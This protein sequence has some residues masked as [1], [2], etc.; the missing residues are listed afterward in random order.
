[1][2]DALGVVVPAHDE[3]RLLPSC[4]AALSGAASAPRAQAVRV[5]VVV[6]LDR[7]TD[8]SALV[9]ALHPDVHPLAL[10]AGNVGRARAVGVELV[11]AIEQRTPPDRVWLATTDADSQVPTDWLTTQLALAR[12]GAAAVVGTVAVPD[13]S[14]HEA[15]VRER[16]TASYQ[17]RERHPHV[18]G[19]NLGVRLSA[20]R[21]AGGFPPLAGDEDVALVAALGQHGVV[22]TSAIPVRTSARTTPRV[23]RGFGAHLLALGDSGPVLGPGGAAAYDPA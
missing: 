12:S 21:S 2:I 19:A 1:V 14:G 3:E 23:R 10:D 9:V 13:W 22:R 17:A 16:W 8:G 11:G 6:V 18:H 20:Y 4:L 15:V 5:H 7:C